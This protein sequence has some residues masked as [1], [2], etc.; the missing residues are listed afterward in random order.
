MYLHSESNIPHGF[1]LRLNLSNF[2]YWIDTPRHPDM[3]NFV[4][5]L[6]LF[7]LDI[8]FIIPHCLALDNYGL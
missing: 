3:R 7:I 4:S 1:I 5:L 2:L 6:Q 8:L